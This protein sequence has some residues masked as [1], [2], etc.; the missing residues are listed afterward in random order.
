MRSEIWGKPRFEGLLEH[1]LGGPEPIA[2]LSR[3]G[4]LYSGKATKVSNLET[5]CSLACRRRLAMASEIRE[6]SDT[7]H[8]KTFT[9]T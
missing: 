8:S 2:E 1:R 3:E 9:V 5:F 6:S 7:V 4:R